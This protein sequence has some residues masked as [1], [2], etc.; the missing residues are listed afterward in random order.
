MRKLKG[1]K[2]IKW[3]GGE[4]EFSKEEPELIWIQ[5]VKQQNKKNKNAATAKEQIITTTSFRLWSFCVCC[6]DD[7]HYLYLGGEWEL[8]NSSTCKRVN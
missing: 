8:S 5:I 4:K 7:S 1:I 6:D 3:V 2:E